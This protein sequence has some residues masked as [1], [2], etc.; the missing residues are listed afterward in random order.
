M[1][2]LVIPETTLPFTDEQYKILKELADKANCPVGDYA[3][4]MIK[5]ILLG[6]FNAR[7]L[8]YRRENPE[9]NLDSQ[10]N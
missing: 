8:L 4:R 9:P 2:E 6:Y 3:L 7:L 10:Q 5:D 1:F